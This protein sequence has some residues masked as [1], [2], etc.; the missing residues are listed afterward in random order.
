MAN[1]F[2]VTLTGNPPMAHDPKCPEVVVL[3]EAGVPMATLFGCSVRLP[4]EVPRH[5][6]FEW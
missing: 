4:D 1:E 2:D 6:C 3:R 5:E